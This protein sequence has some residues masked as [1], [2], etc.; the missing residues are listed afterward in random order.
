VE[1]DATVDP[2]VVERFAEA[3]EH[4]DL[5]A[6]TRLFTE[7]VWG[8]VDDG[9]RRR[10]PTLGARAAYRQWANA[11]RR[12]GRP[13]RVERRRLNGESAILVVIG[14]IALATEGVASLLVIRDPARLLS[15]GFAAR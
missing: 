4:G 3:L 12:F 8:I 14:G 13:E 5:D 1:R 7:D 6:L 11:L 2:R 10:R 15:L 9:E